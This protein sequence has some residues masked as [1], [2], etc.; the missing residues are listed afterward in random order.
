MSQ[1]FPNENVISLGSVFYFF[2]VNT[3]FF[4][5]LAMS[6]KCSFLKQAGMFISKTR[7]QSACHRWRRERPFDYRCGSGQCWHSDFVSVFFLLDYFS[8]SVLLVQGFSIVSCIG[9]NYKLDCLLCAINF[10]RHIKHIKH[11][12]H[13]NLFGS[14]N[15]PMRKILLL[16]ASF[17]KETMPQI[18]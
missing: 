1:E 6:Q 12:I 8:Y 9:V 14:H 13:M 15:D 17:Y 16:L 10:S 7:C 11:F 4:F 5:L 3:I 18:I 2:K